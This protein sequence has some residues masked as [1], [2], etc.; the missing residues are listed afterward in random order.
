MKSL[1]DCRNFP[2]QLARTAAFLYATLSLSGCLSGTVIGP[3]P[4]IHPSENL[5][6]Y[7][8]QIK[9]LRI[10]GYEN[11]LDS[12]I[13]LYE[14]ETF[15]IMATGIIT[16]APGLFTSIKKYP[17][18]L[19]KIWANDEEHRFRFPVSSCGGTFLSNVT[20]RLYFG[21]EPFLLHNNGYFDVT[22]IKWKTD[23]YTKIYEFLSM[24]NSK[25]PGYIGIEHALIYAKA[26]ADLLRLQDKTAK[27]I[28]SASKEIVGIR[29]E[30]R[31]TGS[32][33][34]AQ[35]QRRILALEKKVSA[36]SEKLADLDAK[37]KELLAAQQI[38]SALS[39]ELD[40]KKR[41]EAE[42]IGRSTMAG[43][44]PPLLLITSPVEG[45]QT[46]SETVL[47]NGVA[48]DASGLQRVEI[49][50]TK[51]AEERGSPSRIA[52]ADE[53]SKERIRFE[54]P[55]ML[56]KGANRILVKAINTEGLVAEKTISIDRVPSRTNVWAA[57]VGI[58]DYPNLPKLKYAVNDAQEF[59]R[60]LV[61][62]NRVPVENVMLLLD[63]KAD[64]KNLRKALGT[65]LRSH[66]GENDLVIIFFAGHGATE[67]DTKSPDRDGLEK[68]LLPHDTDPK[69]LYSSAIP[70]REI[71][72]IFER[73]RSE[74]LIFIA[75]ACYSGASGG[76]TVNVTGMRSGLH[77]GFLDRIASGKGKVILS[78]S[79]ANEVSVEKEEL[80][81]GVFTYYLLEGLRGAADADRDGA[82][83]VDEAYRYVSEKVP[84]ATGQE[85]HP[86]KKGS[87][88]GNLVLG[89][90]R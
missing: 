64:L 42:L 66:A 26:M 5:P 20:G 13:D 3:Q 28:E 76:R 25:A 45:I 15:S 85:Q 57:V 12:G 89:I 27:E 7:V 14:G 68:Y 56:V 24:M 74:R 8:S 72:Y 77:D 46:S 60:L 44:R 22:I 43:G 18:S 9:Y 55:V 38:S 32:P 49:Y 59:Y 10:Y 75:D 31:D 84:Q 37:R 67:R 83:T 53:N 51:L 87:V 36:L 80:Q 52:S 54:F 2:G 16:V 33:E 63:E 50:V 70:M 78:A 47:L 1:F 21:I 88:E 90:V 34:A 40:E 29:Q 61:E 4:V 58:N 6:S 30:G 35:R 86:V 65:N 11:Q 17:S 23:D 62:K 19:L 81:H 39:R 73:M 82:V 79:A 71:A 48:E 41:R 69:D